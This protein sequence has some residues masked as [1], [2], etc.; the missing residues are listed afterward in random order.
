MALNAISFLVK[1]FG[2]SIL[3]VKTDDKTQTIREHN[4]I[5]INTFIFILAGNKDNHLL[6]V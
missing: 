2:N 3:V 5:R 4:Y 6:L 1:W